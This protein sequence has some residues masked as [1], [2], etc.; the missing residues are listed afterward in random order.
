[1]ARQTPRT[2]AIYTVENDGTW[3]R[4]GTIR[5]PGTSAREVSAYVLKQLP[6]LDP[7]KTELARVTH[8]ME[9]A[10]FKL[11]PCIVAA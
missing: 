2:F 3:F 6:N 11:D 9:F 4:L 7:N 10:R 1:M 8:K 5:A